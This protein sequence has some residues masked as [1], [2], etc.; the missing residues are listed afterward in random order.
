MKSNCATYYT[1]C[2]LVL[3]QV[4]LLQG[5]REPFDPPIERY[6]NVLV[7]DGLITDGEGPHQVRLTRSFPFTVRYPRQETGA[8]V[9]VRNEA[10]E[11]YFFQEEE[12]GLYLSDPELIGVPGEMYQLFVETADGEQFESEWVELK[13]VPGIDSITYVFRELQEDNNGDIPYALEIRVNTRDPENKTRYYRYEW[14]ETWEFL[15][16]IVSSF[17]PDEQKCWKSN[18]SSQITIATTDHLNTDLLEQYPI[19]AITTRDNRLAIRYSV[20]VTQ[21]AMS[22]EAYEYW[23]ELQEVTQN[24]GTLFDPVPSRVEGNLS[25]LPDGEIPV[26]GRFQAEGATSRRIFID[27]DEVPEAAYIPGGFEHC[28]FYTTSS[29]SEMEYYINRG[30]EFVD[31][32]VDG[33]TFYK[34]YSESPV[35]FRCTFSGTNQRPDYWPQEP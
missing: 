26:L 33:N 32:Y 14:I 2:L 35:C 3:F 6:E 13:P 25:H 1:G 22:R 12:P 18:R 29:P 11:A 23:K 19:Y 15:M 24:T 7:V 31:E 20:L 21:Y 8:L 16:P 10:F 30:F 5:C 34:I 27:R 28:R 4:A 17:Y 9:L